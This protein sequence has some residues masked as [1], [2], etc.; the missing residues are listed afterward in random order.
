MAKTPANQ[1][2]TPETRSRETATPYR[3]VAGL[4]N[5]PDAG[6]M[7]RLAANHS[8]EPKPSHSR[9]LWL[10]IERMLLATAKVMNA[11]TKLVSAI[12]GFLMTLWMLGYI[13]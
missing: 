9:P 13:G 2:L 3:C 1:S 11:A 7:K 10:V 4:T 6:G 5:R 12:T 8:M